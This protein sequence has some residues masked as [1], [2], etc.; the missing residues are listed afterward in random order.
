MRMAS[1]TEFLVNVKD[2]LPAAALGFHPR[3]H[4]SSFESQLASARLGIRSG[5]LDVRGEP[6]LVTRALVPT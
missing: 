2:G 4:E 5:R 6:S 1:T 3:L